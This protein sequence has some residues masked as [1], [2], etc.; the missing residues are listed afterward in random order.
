VPEYTPTLA[1]L[2][3]MV[4]TALL[5]AWLAPHHEIPAASRFGSWYTDGTVE[6]A[7]RLLAGKLLN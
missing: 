4:R 1:E 7:A 3:A 5:S 6:L 2:H